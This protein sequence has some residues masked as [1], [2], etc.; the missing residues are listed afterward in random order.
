MMR[1]H[2]HYCYFWLSLCVF[3]EHT[4]KKH[5]SN[6]S[7]TR[8]PENRFPK[9]TRSE[10]LKVSLKSSGDSRFLTTGGLIGTWQPVSVSDDGEEPEVHTRS[11]EEEGGVAGDSNRCDR[12]WQS[13][14]SKA[15]R[16][17]FFLHLVFCA[18]T[19]RIWGHP[20]RSVLN[21]LSEIPMSYP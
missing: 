14:W 15:K 12:G 6:F 5:N 16:L 21:T 9:I 8:A 4:P 7:K 1:R 2:F 3:K 11:C 20:L 18:L 10:V 13:C 19:H 17:V